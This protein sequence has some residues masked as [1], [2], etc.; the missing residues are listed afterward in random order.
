M[1]PTAATTST[2]PPAARR[3]PM[4]VSAVFFLLGVVLTLFCY[5]HPQSSPAAD[6]LSAP[7]KSLLGQL[8]APV[9]IRYYSL[10]PGN[11]DQALSA[12]AGRVNQLL[13]AMQTASG[14]K[15]Q[16]AVFDKPAETNS[17]AASA[18]GIQAF[19][20][21]KGD[22]CFLGLAIASGKNKESFSRLQPEWEPALEY[23]LARAILRV[24]AAAVSPPAAPEIAK[25][26]AEVV[27]SINRLI[28]DVNATSVETANQIFHAEFMKRCG[29]VSTEI[30]TE[31]NAAQQRVVQAQNSGSPADLEAAQKNLSE[32]QL[33]QAD[34]IKQIAA[35]LTIQMAVF[36]RM[37]ASATNATK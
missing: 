28:P 24:T 16:V 32:V 34:K 33:A 18:D 27:A 22:A 15:M 23:D 21:D 14:G 20:L 19:N 8:S 29:E 12:F 35:H 25:P 2:E 13:D 31:M 9:A 3:R 17:S 36:Q 1:K 6:G 10:L 4:L 26:S 5:H 11:T 37:K 30:E 7:T